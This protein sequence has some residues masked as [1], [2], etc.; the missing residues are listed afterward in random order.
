M[1]CSQLKTGSYR[2]HF[3]G[4]HANFFFSL[5]R[6]DSIQTETNE[7][8]GSISKLAI[9]WTDKCKYELKFIE[10][11]ESFPDSIQNIRKSIILKTEI[12]SWTDRYYI[13]RSTR[14]DIDFVLKDTMWMK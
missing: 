2:Y 5:D 7:K 12:L 14:D 9:R 10:S 13:F 11:T 3:R 6:N 8:T 4:Q 1:D